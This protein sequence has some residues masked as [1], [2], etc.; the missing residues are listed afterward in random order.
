MINF[1]LFILSCFSVKA[2]YNSLHTFLKF[3]RQVRLNYFFSLPYKK[4]NILLKELHDKHFD[5]WKDII[6]SF[7]QV[8]ERHKILTKEKMTEED[9][10]KIRQLEEEIYGPISDEYWKMMRHLLK[11]L[12]RERVVNRPKPK[13]DSSL[14]DNDTLPIL[15]QPIIDLIGKQ[16]FEGKNQLLCLY[17]CPFFY[18]SS[19]KILIEVEYTVVYADEDH[20]DTWLDQW[21]DSIRE[22]EYGRIEDMETFYVYFDFGTR[23][24]VGISTIDYS[25]FT[26]M[27]SYGRTQNFWVWFPIHYNGTGGPEIFAF[28]ANRPYIWVNTWSHLMGTRDENRDLG[29]I[30]YFSYPCL[31][32]GAREDAEMDYINRDNYSISIDSSRMD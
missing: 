22:S 16:G 5:V 15:V 28:Y 1:I 4:R 2:S 12:R 30:Y 14:L 24:I 17:Y 13:C 29:D 6:K 20:P 19:K 21:Y 25:S 3:T 10:Q 31:K 23:N 9:F 26:Y 11:N 32:L 18:E 7:P 8:K 27:N